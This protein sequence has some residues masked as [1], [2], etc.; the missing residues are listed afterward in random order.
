M[1]IQKSNNKYFVCLACLVGKKIPTKDTKRHE[2][3]LL[4][5]VKRGFLYDD[6]KEQ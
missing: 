5:L 4:F 2:S 6:T 1:T 3:F